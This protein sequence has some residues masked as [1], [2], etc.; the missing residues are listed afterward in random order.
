MLRGALTSSGNHVTTLQRRGE[1][2]IA[3]KQFFQDLRQQY[4]RTIE[5]Q[6]KQHWKEFLADLD[7]IWKA[8]SYART[9]G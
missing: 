9:I 8:N 7:I 5:K 4:F 2:T 1:E 6:K 3:A